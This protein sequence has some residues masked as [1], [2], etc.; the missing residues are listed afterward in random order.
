MAGAGFEFQQMRQF[1][2]KFK[3]YLVTHESIHDQVAHRIALL[4]IRKVKKLTPVDTGNLR[5]N[6]KYTIT[7][8][9]D[10]YIIFIENPAHYALFVE[11]GHRIVVAGITVG[12]VEGRFMMKL[13][14]SEIERIAPNMWM[15]EVEKEMRKA[16]G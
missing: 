13:M 1:R 10:T 12:W 9:G 3:N 15:R 8:S 14:E 5:Q 11:K 6:W 2:D 16:F 4:A 7:K